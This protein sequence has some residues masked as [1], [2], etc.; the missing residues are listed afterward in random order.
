MDCFIIEE[1]SMVDDIY[2]GL[3]NCLFDV[4]KFDVFWDCV[5]VYIVEK[6]QFVLYV[7]VGFDLEY[8]LL[9]KM[10]IEMVWQNLFGCN[11]FICLDSY[12][13]VDKQEWQILNVV[14][15]ECDFEWDGINSNG[16]VMINFVKC[17]VL[18]VG[19]Y[20]VG[21][22]KKVMFLVQNFLFLEKDVLLMYCFVNVGEDGQICLFFGLFGIGKIMF[23]VDLN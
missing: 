10:I 9:V 14:N 12:N 1:L 15:F 8:Y 4:D 22:M 11:L 6:D 23:F 17:K 16:V 19:M 21:E 3:I 2:W 13:L 20:Y 18:L 7:Y 5:E